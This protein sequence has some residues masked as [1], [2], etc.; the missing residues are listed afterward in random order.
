MKK[1]LLVFAILFAVCLESSAQPYFWKLEKQWGAN[2]GYK[3]ADLKYAPIDAA[4]LEV[5]Y[6]M[7]PELGFE[8]FTGMEFG[9]NYFSFSPLGMLGGLPMWIYSST[10]GN[11]PQTNLVTALLAAT[12]ARVVIN[13]LDYVEVCPEWDL[14]KLTKFG[15]YKME[16]YG[17][18]GVNIKVYPFYVLPLYISSS[19][20]YNFAYEKY[21]PF[22]GWTFGF[23]AGYY[24]L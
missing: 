22:R 14:L 16:V 2:L 1:F 24:F 4:R 6:Y 3:R 19:I 23:T 21:S 8:Y 12:S 7:A 10:H 5:H 20:K 18:V 11:D 17:D 15:D 13:I 9:K